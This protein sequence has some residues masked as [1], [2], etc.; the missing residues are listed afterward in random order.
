MKLHDSRNSIVNPPYH[1]VQNSLCL[2]W[3]LGPAARKF[4]SGVLLHIF[5]LL[6]ARDG[7]YISA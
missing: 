1:K 6:H 5:T 2:G 4:L 3:D 7:P